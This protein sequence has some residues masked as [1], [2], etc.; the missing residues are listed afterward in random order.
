[1]SPTTDIKQ[2]KSPDS[3]NGQT[4]LEDTPPGPI[5]H[6]S[7]YTEMQKAASAMAQGAQG[8]ASF[9]HSLMGP[10]GHGG[11]PQGLGPMGGVSNGSAGDVGQMLSEYQSL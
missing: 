6:P 11:H 9:P 4:K 8:A 10:Q 3:L 5:P 7:V 2:E 1:M